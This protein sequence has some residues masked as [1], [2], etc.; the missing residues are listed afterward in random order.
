VALPKKVKQGG[1]Y[2]KGYQLSVPASTGDWVLHIDTA[3]SRVVNGM[4]FIADAYGIGDNWS[5]GHYANTTTG[6]AL[7]DAIANSVY[8]PGE[9]VAISLDFPALEPMN[10]GEDLRVTYSNVASTAV[11]LTVVVE[12]VR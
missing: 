10:P 9:N 3:I 11:S 4:T 1:S 8:N 5:V 6:A 7:V 12:F 2:Y